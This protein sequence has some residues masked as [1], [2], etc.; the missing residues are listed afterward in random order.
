MIILL[1]VG[2]FFDNVMVSGFGGKWIRLP[3]SKT[4]VARR[5]LEH[6]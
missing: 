6:W 2:L 5:G 4:L 3:P 1:V